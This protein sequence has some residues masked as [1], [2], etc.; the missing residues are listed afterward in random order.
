MALRWSWNKF[1]GVNLAEILSQK[2]LL[3]NL[4]DG[5][6]QIKLKYMCSKKA[7]FGVVV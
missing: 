3:Q 6:A 7:V 2:K 1:C 5:P 4:F